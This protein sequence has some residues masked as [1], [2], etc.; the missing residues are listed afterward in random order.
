MHRISIFLLITLLLVA[1]GSPTAA[2]PSPPAQAP[3]AEVDAPSPPAQADRLVVMSHDSFSLSQEVLA[4]FEA[5]TGARVEF[6]RM[7]DT[8]S[9]LNQ[10][11]LSRDAPLADVFF[12]IDNTFLS[13][14]LEADIFVPYAAPALAEIP[15]ELQL[16]PEQRL[17]PVD[18]G[19]VL[20][21]YDRAALEARGRTPPTSL[22][23]LMLNE[24]RGQL[25]VQN[26]A[27]S[28]PGLAFLLATIAYFG[29]DGEYSWQ[30]FWRALRKNEVAVSQGWSEAYY[31][32]FSGSSGEGPYPLVV[33]Y[34]T[35][36]AAEVFFSDEALD[37]PPTGNLIIPGG[38][39]R[40]IEF[41]GILRGTQN[42]EL[43]Q[44]FVD[45]ML[46]PTFQ[47]DIPLQMFVYPANPT[48]PLPDVFTRFAEVPAQP[49]IL[50]PEEIE[51]NRERWI[52]EW[53]DV[54]LR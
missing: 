17:L 13:R 43:A 16:D 9:A 7:G 4:T 30:D 11:I 15:A 27:T 29:E 45:F 42:E 47:A 31:T 37:E 48:T 6:L 46:G 36:P 14:A 33:S 20:I 51:Q 52:E 8:G 34:S 40:Q 54:V 23:D 22:E 41:V 3:G 39:F 10:A 25:V 38:V 28:S 53:L 21:N 35:S 5:E 44:R 32:Q 19:Y 12:G 49:T 24:W 26:P 50:S 1:C 18:F 2:P